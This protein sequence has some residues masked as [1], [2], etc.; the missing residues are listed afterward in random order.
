M[1]LPLRDLVLSARDLMLVRFRLHEIK[2]VCPPLERT[3]P[4]A[5]AFF[6][7]NL[8]LGAL[9]NIIDNAIYWL[10]VARPEG[11]PEAEARRLYIDIVP[12]WPNGPAIVVADNGTG[13]WTP[14]SRW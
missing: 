7:F 6:A 8:A 1:S 14:R 12:D 5:K 11:A 13:F 9:T 2:L 4:Y 3:G 10:R